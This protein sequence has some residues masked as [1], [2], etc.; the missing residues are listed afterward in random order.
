[1]F[2]FVT[3]C[4]SVRKSIDLSVKCVQFLLYKRHPIVPGIS[5]LRFIVLFVKAL[6]VY[7]YCEE[8]IFL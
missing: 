8:I 3:V 1:M 6:I 7:I 5:A 4:L 2:F